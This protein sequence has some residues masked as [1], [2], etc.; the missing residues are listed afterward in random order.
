LRGQVAY[1]R[2]RTAHDEQDVLA[3][4]DRALNH[5]ERALRIA[6][7]HA[8]GLELRGTIRYWKY[9][10]TRGDDPTGARRLL[11]DAR[12]DLEESV[13]IQPLLASA[14]STLSHLLYREDVSSAVLA[15]RR[16]YE[17][18]AYLD[19]AA[20]VLVRLTNGYYDIENFDQ[21]KTWCDEASRRFPDNYRFTFCQL[22]LLTTRNVDPNIDRAWSL[23]DQLGKL[24]P[25]HNKQFQIAEG[26]VLVGGTIA[27]ASRVGGGNPALADSARKVLSRARS[28]ISSEIDPE[29]SLLPE[30]AYMYTLLGDNRSAI[31]LLRR[32]AATNP[33]YSFEH[34]WW[35]RDLRGTPEFQPLLAQ[36]HRPAHTAAH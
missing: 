30:T 26:T 36:G 22:L 32:H 14:H 15:A 29:Q 2:S 16:A 11:A 24:A 7:N 31:E 35:W 6:P 12:A 20:D 8:Q 34:H 28:L 19:V 25:E 21:M 1:R 3:F 17:A 13:R 5:A 27:R 4:A 10:R 18:D 33:H 9:L 23:L